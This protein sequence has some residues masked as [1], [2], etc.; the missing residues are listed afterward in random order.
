[1]EKNNQKIIPGAGPFYFE[2][3]KVGILLI[4]GGGGGTSADL[5][6]LAEDLYMNCGYTINLPLL[7]GYGTTPKDLKNTKIQDWKSALDKELSEIMETCEKIIVGGHS[8]GGVL[9]LILAANYNF[10]AIFTISAPTG[11]KRFIINFIPLFNLFIKY[12]TIDSEQFRKDTQGKWI[13]YDKIPL[14]IITKLKKLIREI[15]KSLT[16]I[17]CPALLFQG[18]LDSEIK[19][20]SMNYIFNNINSKRKEKIW[21]ENNKHPI[22]D[23]PNHDQ[24]V[25]ELVNFIN[26]FCP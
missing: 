17:N 7:P 26:D 24:I 8:M 11:I 2:G 16:D 18:L 12:H 13:G 19:R 5:K 10:D 25:L 23:S 6:P 22:L 15:K 20:N 9:T 4:H 3:S 1:M 14:N 21:L